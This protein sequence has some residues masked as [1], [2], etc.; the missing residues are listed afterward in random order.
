MEKD[1]EKAAKEYNGK[2]VSL[3]DLF[4]EPFMKANT[5]F[6]DFDTWLSA[7]AWLCAGE[8]NHNINLESLPESALDAYVA[9]STKFDSWQKMLNA[10]GNEMLEKDI[11][12]SN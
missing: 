8:C 1:V 3:E 10:A 12:W 9:K 4:T 6:P 2:A 11:G 7:E 5:D